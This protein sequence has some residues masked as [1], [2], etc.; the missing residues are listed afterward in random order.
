VIRSRLATSYGAEMTLLGGRA[1]WPWALA[2]LVGAVL[3]PHAVSESLALDLAIVGAAA[4][5]AIGLNIVTGWAGQVSLGQAFFIGVGAYTACVLGGEGNGGLVGLGLDMAIWLPASGAVAGI[6]GLLVAPIAFRLRGLYLAI[7]TLGLVFIGEHVFRAATR[8]T[9]GAGTGR[10]TPVPEL[11]GFRFDQPGEILGVQVGRAEGLCLLALGVLVIMAVA[12]RNIGRSAV[13][14]EL[15]AVRDRDV[16]A[17]IMGVPIRRAKTLAFAL[18][19][20]YAGIAGALLFLPAGFV[21]P[22]SFD[23]LLS[24]QYIAM[25]LIGGIG[26]VSGAIIGA[27]FVTLLPRIVSPLADVVPGIT[28]AA[29]GGVLTTFQLQQILYGLLI[30]VFL[31]LEPRGVIGLWTRVRNYFAAWPFAR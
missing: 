27:A 19:S 2:A 8:L 5:G 16:A 9:G 20:F 21:E 1:R 4:I 15:A 14:R 22:G 24:V 11:F 28:D 6:A 23:L 18:S 3:L 13:G 26:T 31:V 10:A 7:V 30:V 17:A 12:A 29:S 25:V